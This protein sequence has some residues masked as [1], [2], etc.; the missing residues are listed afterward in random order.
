MAAKKKTKS[1]VKH[2]DGCPARRVR[3]KYRQFVRKGDWLRTSG[4]RCD[5][6]GED[7]MATPKKFD[8]TEVED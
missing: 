3:P 5:D 4:F 2:L 6:C 8:P 1:D 7:A